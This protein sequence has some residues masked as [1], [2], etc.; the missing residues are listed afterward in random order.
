MENL[1]Y[2]CL[3]HLTAENVQVRTDCCGATGNSGLAGVSLVP[4]PNGE[5]ALGL[6][7]CESS[8]QTY[9]WGTGVP[10]PFT[11]TL[12]SG[13][14]NCSNPTQYQYGL[15]WVVRIGYYW[16]YMLC[17]WLLYDYPDNARVFQGGAC[18]QWSL[19]QV[20]AALAQPE[21]IVMQNCN[22]GGCPTAGDCFGGGPWLM[23]G[24]GGQVT[25][26]W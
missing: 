24:V 6:S 20:H 3:I 2:P 5:H 9:V 1:W 23:L 22:Q 7:L 26:R 4:D 19:A 25:L 14:Q 15:R 16:G 13:S 17:A 18:Y 11:L 12:L 10:H 21:G 8:Y